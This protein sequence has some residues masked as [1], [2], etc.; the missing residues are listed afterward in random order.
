MVD[1]LENVESNIRDMLHAGRVAASLRLLRQWRATLTSADGLCPGEILVWLAVEAPQGE[2]ELDAALS[3][4]W[5]DRRLRARFIARHG[6]TVLGLLHGAH[7]AEHDKALVSQKLNMRRQA[8][9]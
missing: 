1:K 2:M 3:L 8:K 4:V 7:A 9:I 5:S 6:L